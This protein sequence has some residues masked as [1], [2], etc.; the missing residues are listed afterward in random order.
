MQEAIKI[1]TALNIFKKKKEEKKKETGV[2]EKV[3]V[4]KE[5]KE[6][7]E[8]VVVKKEKKPVRAKKV[9]TSEIWR[10]L[11]KPH[12][13]EKATE[14]AKKGQYIFKVFNSVNKKEVREAIEG[15]YGVN[16]ESVKIINVGPRKRRLGK[17]EGLKKGYK[18]AI[19]RLEEGQKIEVLPR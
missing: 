16:V 15:L 13:T 5:E 11:K 9:R 17:I 3:E 6:A 8:A 14:L 1:M 4:P 19:V 7:P 10:I 18:K 2:P 12:V